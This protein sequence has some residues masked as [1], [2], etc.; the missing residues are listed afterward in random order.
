[1]A[2]Y[3]TMRDGKSGWIVQV[4][5][6]G[7]AVVRSFKTL[8]EARAWIAAHRAP[9]QVIDTAEPKRTQSVIHSQKHSTERPQQNRKHKAS[10]T[11]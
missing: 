10:R 8:A 4:R 11:D 9:G 1:M 3:S 7:G 5:E 2:T 6:G